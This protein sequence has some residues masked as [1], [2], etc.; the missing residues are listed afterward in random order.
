VG[1]GLL[2]FAEGFLAVRYGAAAKDFV[3]HQKW[4]S[5]AIVLALILVVLA[6]R[7]LQIDRP[8]APSETD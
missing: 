8:G 7:R 4:A 1:R 6:I 5:L 2:F 3:L